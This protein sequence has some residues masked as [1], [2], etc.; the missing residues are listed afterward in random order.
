MPSA[1]RS[2]PFEGLAAREMND[3]DVKRQ[4]QQMVMFIRQ[5]AEEKA[6]EIRVSAEEDFNIEKLQ[7]VEAEKQR[8][9][10]EYERKESQV[11]VQR[12]IELSMQRNTARLR[13]LEARE[14]LVRTALKEVEKKLRSLVAGPQYR[15]ILKQLIAQGAHTIRTDECV[16]RCR[17]VDI[18]IVKSVLEEAGEEYKKVY[19]VKEAPILSVDEKV[20]LPPPPKGEELHGNFCLGGVLLISKNGKVSCS[21]T[22]D[23]RLESAAEM[24]LPKVRGPFLQNKRPDGLPVSLSFRC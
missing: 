20:F 21:N 1:E 11:E 3:E 22:L 12:M 4:I 6:S 2:R 10:K 18:D 9:R 24:F 23:E 5:E 13:V 15:S 17:E 19:G 7:M 8:I 16:I 14:K